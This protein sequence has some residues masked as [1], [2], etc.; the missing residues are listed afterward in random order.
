WL[1][2]TFRGSRSRLLTTHPC[3]KSCA[4]VVSSSSKLRC[5]PSRRRSG[6][7]GSPDGAGSP[8]H[9]REEH[10]A[11]GRSQ[12]GDLRGGDGRQQGGDSPGGGEDLQR[13]GGLRSNGLPRGQVEA[14]G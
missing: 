1:L 14:H 3:I 13:Q 2:A 11:E 6:H 9:D 5:L 4:T 12:R 7:E 8:A 10:A